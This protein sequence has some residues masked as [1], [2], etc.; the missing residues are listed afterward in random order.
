MLYKAV[1]YRIERH[2]D[3]LRATHTK[4][5]RESE[6][7]SHLLEAPHAVQDVELLPALGEV[8]FPIKQVW[9]SQMYECQV[10]QDQPAEQE[11]Q[12]ETYEFI[13]LL[14]KHVSLDR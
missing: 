7:H 8:H 12:R 14:K 3:A 4:W 1:V 10:L 13:S 6:G 9:I 11:R 5:K 2:Q